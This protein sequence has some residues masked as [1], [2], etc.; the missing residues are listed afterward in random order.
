[1]PAPEVSAFGDGS[2]APG[3]SGLTID[4][5]GFGAFPGSVW[6]FE[7]ADLTGNADELTVNAWNDLEIGVDIP[8]SLNNTAGTRYLFVQR[9]DLAWSNP[10]SFTLESVSGNENADATDSANATDSVTAV[11]SA[12]VAVSRAANATDAR[13]ALAA[14]LASVSNAADGSDDATGETTGEQAADSADSAAGSDN[15]VSLAAARSARALAAAG[16]DAAAG[17]V[18]ATASASDAAVASDSAS[19][20]SSLDV[21]IIGASSVT[22]RETFGMQANVA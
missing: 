7:N 9:E 5:G 15:V 1:M 2:H 20:S 19:A 10:F 13:T 6:I 12:L 4:G 3:A 8:G 21:S 18:V 16:S 11:A 14:A 17:R 22:L